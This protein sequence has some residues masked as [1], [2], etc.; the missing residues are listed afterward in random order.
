MILCS[1]PKYVWVFLNSAKYV[2]LHSLFYQQEEQMVEVIVIKNWMA[3]SLPAADTIM[4]LHNAV[5][6]TQQQLMTKRLCVTCL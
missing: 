3:E 1:Q 6:R 5:E 2:D 4:F